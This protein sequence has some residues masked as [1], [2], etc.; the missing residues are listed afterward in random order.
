M[1]NLEN[2]AKEF[3][4]IKKSYAF[5]SGREIWVFADSEKLNDHKTWEVARKIKEKI[6][7]DIIIP[8]EIIIHVIREKRFVQRLN[9]E[10]EKSRPKKKKQISH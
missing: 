5:Q 9:N 7:K 1:N 4:G 8:G 10:K 6:K 3:P 2:I